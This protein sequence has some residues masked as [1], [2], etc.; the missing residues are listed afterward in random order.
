MKKTLYFP[1]LLCLKKKL[2]Q[3][4][5]CS[6]SGCIQPS[7][8]VVFCFFLPHNEACGV[9]VPQPRNEPRCPAVAAGSPNHWTARESLIPVLHK[10]TWHS[11]IGLPTGPYVAGWSSARRCS[12]QVT[13]GS[14][15]DKQRPTTGPEAD[16]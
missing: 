13:G 16:G 12:S 7:L 15:R 5:M 3:I 8:S 4:G 11:Y 10:T 9:L 14:G 6:L 2:L 1:L